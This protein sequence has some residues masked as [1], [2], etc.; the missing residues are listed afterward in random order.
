MPPPWLGGWARSGKRLAALVGRT[1]CAITCVHE[2]SAPLKLI[3]IAP[4]TVAP[5]VAV[6]LADFTSFDGGFQNG[7]LACG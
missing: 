1:P 6:I 7:S 2:Q 3:E 5:E 4:F